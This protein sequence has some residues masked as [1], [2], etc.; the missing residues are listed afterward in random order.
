MVGY[1]RTR[2]ADIARVLERE[3]PTP[4]VT[5]QRCRARLIEKCNRPEFLDREAGLYGGGD[6]G[7]HAQA[8]VLDIVPAELREKVAELPHPRHHGDSSAAT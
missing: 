3:R 1:F 4:T 8:L 6:Q 7:C 2:G 5:R